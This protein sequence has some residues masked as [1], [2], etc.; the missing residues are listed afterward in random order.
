[1]RGRSGPCQSSRLRALGAQGVAM[2]FAAVV[3][4]TSVAGPG[5]RLLASYTLTQPKEPRI[6]A[7]W[8]G[9]ETTISWTTGNRRPGRL[10]VSFGNRDRLLA[11]ASRGSKSLRWVQPGV[12]YVFRLYAD[13]AKKR[14][15]ASLTLS[16]SRSPRI[17]AK[18][19]GRSTTISWRTGNDRPGSLYFSEAGKRERL[20]ARASRGS[21]GLSWVRP[22]VRYVFRIYAGGSKKHL[23]T[24]YTLLQPKRPR[25]GVAWFG[26]VSAINWST[27]SNRVGSLYVSQQGGRLRLVAR[28][29]RNSVRVR[30]IEPGT[31]YVFKLYE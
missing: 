21:E 9:V 19:F 31:R 3:A 7:T 22:G 10:Y 2:M 24:S 26:I 28:G 15:L 6:N 14:L 1:M 12:R 13:S 18:W 27:G 20:L 25:I 17:E 11:Y 23:L 5:K 8:F 16:Q 29:T 30:W 4:S